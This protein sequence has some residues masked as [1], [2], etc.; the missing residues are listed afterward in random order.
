MIRRALV[1]VSALSLSTAC[2]TDHGPA[3][4]DPGPTPFER[5]WS[6]TIRA[7]DAIIAVPGTSGFTTLGLPI[8][9][10][11][12]P[13]HPELPPTLDARDVLEAVEVLEA[14][15]AAAQRA[16][17]SDDAIEAGEVELAM[18]GSGITKLTSF[19]YQSLGGLD[20]TF[21]VIGG[22]SICAFGT[23]LD[24]LGNYNAGNADKDAR[25]L[26]KRTQA[27][28]QGTGAAPG[29]VRN[30][31]LV[32]HSWGGVVAEYLATNLAMFVAAHGPLPGAKVAF[33]IAGGVP[34]FV[35]NIRALGPGFRTIDSTAGD[36]SS[37]VKTYE[38]NRPDDPVHTFD[39]AGN[40]GGHHY[41]IMVGDDYA[42]WYG[43][44]TD[45]LSCKGIPGICPSR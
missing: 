28:L 5:V 11:I 12:D 19:R 35:P 30:L 33:V 4:T 13:R 31:T 45:E 39:P 2:A 22:T 44:T 20:V 7:G 36:V 8:E 23:I 18:W 25:D 14:A 3:P 41:V 9:Q 26:Y 40:G 34:A 42:G 15:I 6:E 17:F 24:N 29:T 32:S 43:I 10:A 16:G 37:A 38:V 21:D 27:W 1:L